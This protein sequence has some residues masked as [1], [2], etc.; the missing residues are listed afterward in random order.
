MAEGGR[1]SGTDGSPTAGLM[2]IELCR[3]T[4][5]GWEVI[6]LQVPEPST[7]R[8]A[9]VASGW[10]DRMDD[11]TDGDAASI[12]RAL[13]SRR[14]D[15]PWAVAIYGRRVGLDEPLHAHDRV[16][17]LAPVLVDPMVARQRRA[18]HRR[19]EAGERRWARDRDPRLPRRPPPDPTGN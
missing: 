5:Q 13:Q 18:E 7:V 1:A 19:R 9:L 2:P 16:E 17:L 4:A 14:I 3:V 11:S 12:W 15:A 10:F 6:S 8:Q